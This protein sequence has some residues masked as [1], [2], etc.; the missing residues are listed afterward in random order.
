MLEA[1]DPVFEAAAVRWIARLPA[2]AAASP[3][4]L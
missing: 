3:S 2:N 1:D 4:N